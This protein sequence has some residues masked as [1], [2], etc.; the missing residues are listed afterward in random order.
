MKYLLL[1]SFSVMCPTLCDPWT[2][3]C[4]SFTISQSLLKL[5]SI[6]SVMPSNHLI[7]CCPVLLLQSFPASGCFPVSWLFAS[8]GRS[9]G[10]SA[11]ASVLPMNVQD[12]FS[13]GLTGLISLLSKGLSRL[14][15]NTTV[16]NHLWCSGFFMVQLSHQYITTRETIAL[17]IR[18][19]VSK[20]MSAFAY[21]A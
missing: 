14:F 6:K 2:A 15:S 16:Q 7:L 1:F 18:T 20:V 8:G 13:L 5:M 9:I 3:V 4:L 11:S 12:R 17:T 19:F 21:A 10:A